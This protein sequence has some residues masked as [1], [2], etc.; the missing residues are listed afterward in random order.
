VIEVSREWLAPESISEEAYCAF[1]EVEVL[2]AP[3]CDCH[4]VVIWP[5]PLKARST[6]LTTPAGLP[7]S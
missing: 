7:G 5:S 1:A 3:E 6:W 2:T 4:S